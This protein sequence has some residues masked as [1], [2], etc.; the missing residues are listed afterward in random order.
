M[1]DHDQVEQKEHIQHTMTVTCTRPTSDP[2]K[3]LLYGV[4]DFAHENVLTLDNYVV[5]DA[6]FIKCAV[7]PAVYS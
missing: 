5:N 6:I 7:E 3:D 2:D 4:T 1:L